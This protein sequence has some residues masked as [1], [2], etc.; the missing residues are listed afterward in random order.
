MLAKVPKLNHINI[1]GLLSASIIP[2]LVI[3]PFFPDLILSIL[4]L[5]FIFFT[6]KNK[7][8]SQYK[9]IYFYI[10]LIFCLICL[11]SSILSDN[12]LLSFESSLF[13][14][15]IGVFALFISY[16]INKDKKILDYFYY[17]FLITYSILAF[18]GFFQYF[19]GF[20][21]FG[22]ELFSERVSLFLKMNLS[23]DLTW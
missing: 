9:N 19:T 16:L 21:I 6:L 20:N 23:W 2:F 14:F 1:L 15:R 10:F 11:V 4:S 22:Y 17:S 8:Y 13:Y 3:G 12:V 18:D 7:I 5:G